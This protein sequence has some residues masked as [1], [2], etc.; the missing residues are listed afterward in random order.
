VSARAQRAA[1]WFG[2]A[3]AVVF[4]FVGIMIAVGFHNYW[5]PLGGY[6]R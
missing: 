4:T 5:F 2:A 3:V 1:G 6:V